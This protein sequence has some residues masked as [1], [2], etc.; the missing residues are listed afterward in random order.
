[1]PVLLLS[2][3]GLIPMEFVAAVPTNDGKWPILRSKSFASSIADGRLRSTR[4]VALIEWE[5]T[6]SQL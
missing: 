6:D 1:M 2:R 3:G 4:R 5:A